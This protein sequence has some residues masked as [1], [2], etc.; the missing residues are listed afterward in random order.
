[1][2]TV[3]LFEQYM[4]VESAAR[5]LKTPHTFHTQEQNGLASISVAQPRSEKSQEKL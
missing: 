2:Q 4:F 3:F 5:R 1:M